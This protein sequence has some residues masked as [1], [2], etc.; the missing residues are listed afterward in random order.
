MKMTPRQ[1]NAYHKQL[2]RIHATED[3]RMMRVVS[4]PYMS[5]QD[6]SKLRDNLV[7]NAQGKSNLVV[8]KPA[9]VRQFLDSLPRAN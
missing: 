3:L 8:V 7:T 5:K 9:E 6:Y 2:V 1:I 4:A